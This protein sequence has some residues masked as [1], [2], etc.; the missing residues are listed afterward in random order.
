MGFLSLVRAITMIILIGALIILVAA[1]LLAIAFYR[2]PTEL[3][4]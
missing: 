2:I 3:P 1:I 4:K